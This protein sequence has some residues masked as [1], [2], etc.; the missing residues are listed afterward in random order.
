MKKNAFI[1]L[2]H[3][4]NKAVEFKFKRISS[5]LTD[6]CDCYLVFDTSNNDSAINLNSRIVYK[7]TPDEIESRLGYDCYVKGTITPGSGIFPV[8]AFSRNNNYLYYWVIEYDFEFTGDYKLLINSLINKKVD[9]AACHF[10]SYSEQPS[11]MWWKTIKYHDDP[12]IGVRQPMYRALLPIYRISNTALKI[13]D[14][15]YLDGFRGHCEGLIPTLLKLNNLLILDFKDFTSF[16]NCNHSSLIS[17]STIRATPTID[18]SVLKDNFKENTFY[19]PI[20]ELCAFD[21]IQN[22]FIFF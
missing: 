18:M 22:K 4:W 11:W 19:H 1:L 21:S 12:L 3:V 15:Q 6:N 20:K 16:Y 5:E 10:Y 14:S 17:S 13:L 2:T 7:F 8:I 9:L